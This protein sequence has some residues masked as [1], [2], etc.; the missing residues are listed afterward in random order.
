MKRYIKSNLTETTF[1]E[2]HDT[3][4]QYIVQFC[5]V[6]TDKVIAQEVYTLTLR[7]VIDNSF[8]EL[9][10]GEYFVVYDESGEFQLF[11]S[12]NDEYNW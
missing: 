11:N 8:Y 4:N 6:V 7:Q 9:E 12:L 1:D 2:Y 3:I 5:D 10:D